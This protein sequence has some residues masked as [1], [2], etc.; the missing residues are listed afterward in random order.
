MISSLHIIP[1]KR[2]H[3]TFI[4]DLAIFKGS[5]IL[6]NGKREIVTG[7][8]NKGATLKIVS[9]PKKNVPTKKCTLLTYNT[10]MICL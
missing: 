2:I 3:K 9:Q 8:F 1:G 5:A 6:Y 7:V 4:K 10:G